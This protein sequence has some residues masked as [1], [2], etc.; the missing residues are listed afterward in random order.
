MSN[1][2]TKWISTCLAAAAFLFASAA[3][4]NAAFVIDSYAQYV[5]EYAYDPFDYNSNSSSTPGPLSVVTTNGYANITSSTASS[6]TIDMSYA[7][8]FGPVD[9]YGEAYVEQVV[10]FHVDADTPYTF[11]ISPFSSGAF[12]DFNFGS[13]YGFNTGY[14]L[15]NYNYSGLGF[16]YSGVLHPG[17][18]YQYVTEALAYYGTNAAMTGHSSLTT[19]VPEPSSIALAGLGGIGLAIGAYRRR[20]AAAAV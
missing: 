15:Y 8:G 19:N 14:E 1:I 13:I 16:S 17:Q 5:E 4:S 12:Y 10:Y 6:T 2:F 11:S 18:Q 9:T 3:P 7:F 20:K